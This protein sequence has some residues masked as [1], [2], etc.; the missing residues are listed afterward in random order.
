[1][2][3]DFDPTAEPLEIDVLRRWTE[4][5]AECAEMTFTGMTHEG[6]RVRVYAV[7]GAPLGGKNLPGILHIHG[8]GQTVSLRWLRFWNE[9]GYAALSFDWAG[10]WPK[11]EQFTRWGKLLQGNL[12][13]VR[14]RPHPGE[15]GKFLHAVEPGVRQSSWYLWTRIGR[16]ALTALEQQPEVDPKRLGV[17]GV[18]M[19]GSMVWP[20]AAVDQRVKAACAIYGVGWNTYPEEIGVPDPKGEEGARNQWRKTMEPEAYAPLVRCP[21]LFLNATNDGHGKMDWAFRTL[22]LVPG[23]HRQVHT[24]RFS[25]HIGNDQARDL[26]LWMDTWLRGGKPWPKTPTVRVR[27]RPD[28][29]PELVVQADASQP[30]DRAELFYAVENRNPRTRFWRS[31]SAERKGDDWTAPLPILEARQPLFA[32]ANVH[33][34]SGIC[35]GSD[36]VT[37]VPGDLGSVRTTDHSTPMIDDF[38]HGTRDWVTRSPAADPDDVYPSLLRSAAGPGGVKGIQATKLVPFHTHKVG[39][40]KWRGF[41]GA[42]LRFQVHTREERQLEIVVV[43]NELARNSRSFT[44]RV[45]LRATAGWQTVTLSAGSFQGDRGAVLSGWSKVRMLELTP[46]GGLGGAEPIFTRFEWVK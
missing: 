19:G 1:V 41:E 31:A 36:L 39:D 38:L 9:R 43:E 21:I 33:Y 15:A 44:A 34:R 35:L 7:Y 5:K 22:A 45:K 25:H 8:G 14:S 11:R 10:R 17:F 16:R 26:P 28:G 4:G 20:I 13:V 23:E 37:V 42:R 46:K 6:Q 2:W 12:E 30:L 3:A 32:F 27:L 18:S 29:V 24:P 40:P